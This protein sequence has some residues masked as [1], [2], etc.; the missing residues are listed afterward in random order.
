MSWPNLFVRQ[1][2]LREASEL[3]EVTQQGEWQ[4]QDSTPG[5][6]LAFHLILLSVLASLTPEE[7]LV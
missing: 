7:S 4:S 3:P 5:P 1:T 6:L 2:S